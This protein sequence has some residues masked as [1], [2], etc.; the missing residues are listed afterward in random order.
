MASGSGLLLLA[1]ILGI[2]TAAASLA[3]INRVRADAALQAGAVNGSSATRTVV[4][5]RQP[6]A[7][8][9]RISGAM[10][11]SRQIPASLALEGAIL[12]IKDVN[13]RVARYPI[14]AGEQVLGSRLVSADAPSGTGLAFTV[15]ENMRAISVP[16]TE[17][18]GAGG[19]I[20]PGDRVDVLVATEY[21][22]LFGPYE[23]AARQ[24]GTTTDE[25][26]HPTVLTALQDVL[27][28]AVGQ[29]ITDPV[30]GDGDAATLRGE[31]AKAQPKAISVT[32]AVSPDQAQSLFM[33]AKTGT[34]GLV[35]RPFGERERQSLAPLL[36]L[37]PQQATTNTV[38]R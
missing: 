36:K 30:K 4:I 24:T 32:L 21:A 11:E 16:V 27:V 12:D 35:L 31:E 7:A 2:V 13:G 37:Q 19:L 38:Q 22:N 3:W 26:R 29:Q 25:S 20:V 1:T 18:S 33:S 6:I 34:I 8:G 15:P 10:L 28:L 9:A 14:A 5:T 17:V 23:F